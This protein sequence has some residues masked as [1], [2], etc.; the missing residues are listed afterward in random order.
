M[1]NFVLDRALTHKTNSVLPYFSIVVRQNSQAAVIRKELRLALQDCDLTP[2]CVRVGDNIM[3]QFIDDQLDGFELTSPAGANSLVESFATELATGKGNNV[4]G[5]L[6]RYLASDHV[7]VMCMG[8][9]IAVTKGQHVCE[10]KFWCEDYTRIQRPVLQQVD[11]KSGWLKIA[12]VPHQIGIGAVLKNAYRY[13][14]GKLP[15]IIHAEYYTS[16]QTRFRLKLAKESEL[17]MLDSLRSFE[18]EQGTL[19]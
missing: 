19:V 14:W 18:Q 6:R 2:V 5:L 16:R 12:G 13:T 15:S 11:V 8:K 3:I 1:M 9:K 7:D 10:K 4:T 17:E